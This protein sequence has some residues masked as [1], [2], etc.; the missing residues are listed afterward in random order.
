MEEQANQRWSWPTYLL[1]FVSS[2]LCPNVVFYFTSAKFFI[3]RTTLLGV[4]DLAHF[5][6]LQFTFFQLFLVLFV[7]TVGFG[8]TYLINWLVLKM[9]SRNLDGQALF[10]AMGFAILIADAI[11]ILV[12]GLFHINTPTLTA[13]LKVLVLTFC[14]A[15]FT[16]YQDKRGVC[17]LGV[18]SLLIHFALL[19]LK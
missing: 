3:R 14:Y 8:F 11:T 7:S 19:S 5:T 9:L 2:V 1:F 18:L 13:A 17:I 10:V 6:D 12:T 15:S 16:K 4:K